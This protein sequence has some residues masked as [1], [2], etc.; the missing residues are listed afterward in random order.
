MH[1]Q[2]ALQWLERAK[3]YGLFRVCDRA[4]MEEA[5]KAIKPIVAEWLKREEQQYESENRSRD[6]HKR[7]RR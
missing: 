3:I 2:E 1:P 7:S 4:K 5:L 6:V